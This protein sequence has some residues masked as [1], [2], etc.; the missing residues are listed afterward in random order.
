MVYTKI[1]RAR[2]PQILRTVILFC[3]SHFTIQSEEEEEGDEEDDD[4]DAFFEG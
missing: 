1:E 4:E 2:A 3:Q